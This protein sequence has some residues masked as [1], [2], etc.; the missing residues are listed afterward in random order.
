[1]GQTVGRT[2][3]VTKSVA[4]LMV[5]QAIGDGRLPGIDAP[6]GDLVDGIADTG[7][8]RLTLAQLLRMDS[9][10]GFTE[11][12]LPWRDSVRVCH[13]CRLRRQAKR[14]RLKDLVGRFFHYNDWYPLLVALA[15]AL[16]LEQ[17]NRSPV[18]EMLSRGLWAPLGAGAASLSMDRAGAAAIAHVDCGF[19]ASAYAL[20]RL[21]QLVL[22]RGR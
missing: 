17:C 21:G 13:G 15:L 22:Q 5:G 4:S 9:G 11:G 2:M 16:A 8:A 14:V 6:I 10:I 12:L 19:N 20:A 7:V 1:M 18:A 3:S